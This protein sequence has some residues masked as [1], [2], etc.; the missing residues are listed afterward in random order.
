[1]SPRVLISEFL[2]KKISV[3]GE[4]GSARIR[5]LSIKKSLKLYK[6]IVFVILFV[7]SYIEQFILG[8]PGWIGKT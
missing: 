1:M 2:I 6:F 3:G 8:R 5:K 7:F 4:V